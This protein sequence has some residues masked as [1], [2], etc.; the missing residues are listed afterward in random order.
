MSEMVLYRKYRPQNF[1]Q[2]VGQDHVTSTLKNAISTGRIAHAYLFC[3]PRGSGK[4]TVA[5][6]LSKAINCEDKSTP[7]PCNKCSSCKDIIDNRAMD[8]IEIDAAS[9]R[10]IDEIRELRDGVRFSPSKFKYKV[11]ILDEAHQLTSGAANAFLKILEEA[12]SHVVFILAT[13]EPQKMIPTIISR[14]QRFDFRKIS[15]LEISKKLE[16]IVEKEKIKVSK[17]VLSMVASLAGGSMRDAESTL[18]QVLSFVP[19]EGEINKEDVKSFL[20]V[21]ER[22]A[23]G[24]FVDFLLKD[25]A[26]QALEMLEKMFSQGTSPENFHNNLIYYLREM[27]VL[28]IISKTERKDDSKSLISSILVRFTE[29]EVERIRKQIENLEIDDIKKIIDIFFEAGERIKH[30]PLPQLPLEVAV[31]ET[32]ETL[33]KTEK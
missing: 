30:S 2:V 10:G 16:K 8:I 24:D 12:P 29:E 3:G 19:K 11:F 9:H 21:I 27:M 23:V 25:E 7:E 33:R 17:D 31:A 1:S 5:R 15:V 14:C 18:S 4:T 6:L 20:G 32:T 28:K 22:E 26:V 13:T